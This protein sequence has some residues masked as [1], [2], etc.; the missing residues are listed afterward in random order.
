MLGLVPTLVLLLLAGWG[1]VSFPN[2]ESRVNATETTSNKN[3]M[4]VI[5]QRNI[6]IWITEKRGLNV[7]Q[8]KPSIHTLLN[9]QGKV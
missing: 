2:V 5:P 3:G 7:R 9:T 1:H 4:G 8:S 6:N